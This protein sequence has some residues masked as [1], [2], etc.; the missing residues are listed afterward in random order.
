M[1]HPYFCP[2]FNSQQCAAALEAADIPFETL[3]DEELLPRVAQIIA[4][5]GI[6]GWFQGRAEFGPRALGNRSFL[7]DPRRSDMRELLNERVKLREW[8]RP[9]APSLLE[10]STE[11]LFDRPHRDPYMVTVVDVAEE[12]RSKVPAVVHVDG[13]A[14]PQTVSRKTNPRYWSLIR[15]FQTLTGVPVLLNTSFNVQEPIVCT[16]QDAVRTFQKASFDALVL[17]DNLVLRARS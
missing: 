10:E 3:P 9:L 7:A 1:E 6:V 5:G 11:E 14:R 4:D 8:F 17:E 16:P 12:Y 15:E 2:S 13:S